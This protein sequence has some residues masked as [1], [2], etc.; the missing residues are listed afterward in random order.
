MLKGIDISEY[1]SP[2]KMDYDKIA[3]QINF[4]ILRVGFT[5]WGTGESLNADKAFE[6]HYAEFSKRGIPIGVYWFSCANE[7]VEGVDEA[8]KV[9]SLIKGKKIEYPV[10][11]DTEDN[12]HQRPTSTQ[13]LTDTAKAFCETIKKAGYRVG[14]YASTSWLNSELDMRQLTS[15]ETW[16]AHYGV[17]KPSYTGKYGLWQY[18]SVGRL[19]GYVGNLDLNYSYTDYAP[20]PA[21]IPVSIY[22]PKATYTG[23]SI[24]DGL[25]SV[26]VVIVKGLLGKIAKVNGIM[27]Y[28]GTAKQ[29]TKMLTLLKQ[30]ALKKV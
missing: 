4:V 14:I 17:A 27:F 9:L 22:Y 8:N 18:T 11:W 10:Y 28:I 1:Q 15:Y 2:S 29:N 23:G 24:V 12:R 5:G 6:R 25:K 3:K 30:G 26:K 21:P 7:V 16:V 13:V 19:D 20:K